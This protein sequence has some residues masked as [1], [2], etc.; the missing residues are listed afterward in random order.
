[1]TREIYNEKATT[2]QGRKSYINLSVTYKTC[3]QVNYINK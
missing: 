1:M 2:A 3:T